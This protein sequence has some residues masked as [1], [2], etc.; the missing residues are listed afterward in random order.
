MTGKARGTALKVAWPACR[1]VVVVR[2]RA[3]VNKRCRLM[4]GIFVTGHPRSLR[5]FVAH[6][7][8]CTSNCT[9][10]CERTEDCAT[11][12]LCAKP[13]GTCDA[14]GTC[15]ARPARCPRNIEPVGTTYANACDA[16]VHAVSV[17]HAGS[18]G[19]RCGTIVGLGCADGDFCDLP[20][21]LCRGADL[22]G[23]CT[24]VP[25][26]CPQLYAPV[27]GCDGV[28]YPNECA[29]QA[30]EVQKAHDG[31]CKPS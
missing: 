13:V 31:A 22:A 11:G 25:E 21:G 12:E 7:D 14:T 29:R 9:T 6:R 30:S 23:V 27:C 10:A 26:V 24:P 4:R 8:A 20:A 19:D 5:R 1:N 15:Q 18:C 2:L 28:T 3:F 17:A 16:A